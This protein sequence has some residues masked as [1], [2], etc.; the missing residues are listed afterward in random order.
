MIRDLRES[1]PRDPFS[2]CATT[3]TRLCEDLELLRGKRRERPWRKH[4]NL[5]L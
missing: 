2:E 4:G 5:P 1:P 3:R